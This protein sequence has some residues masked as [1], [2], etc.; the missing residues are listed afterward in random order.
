MGP[1]RALPS[2]LEREQMPLS[3][4]DT[5]NKITDAIKQTYNSSSGCDIV[6][7]ID[8][9][10]IGNL[11][12]ISFSTTREKAPI[13]TMGSVD[14]V[15]F[16]RGKRGHA[17]SLIFTNFDRHALYDIMEA[18][19]TAG[20]TTSRYQYWKKLKDIPAGGRS[21]LLNENFD[22]ADL[23][24][25][26]LKLANPNYSDQ[27]PPFTITLTSMNEYGSVSVMHILGVELIN[28]GSGVSIDDI[29]TETQM[30]FVARGILGWRPITFNKNSG[31]FNLES[32]G[33]VERLQKLTSVEQ[34]SSLLDIERPEGLTVG[35]E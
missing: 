19:G 3:S 31:T 12:G 20:Q 33:I 5:L 8:G 23:A 30:T 35:A 13:Y 7:T 24:N 11:N 14:A 10:L 6:A 21:T 29:V 25:L 16:G 34:A 2:Y 32:A 1:V 27:I 18:A 26:G 22:N 4:L 17:G 9:V 28:E 15:S